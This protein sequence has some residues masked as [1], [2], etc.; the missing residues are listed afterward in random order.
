MQAVLHESFDDLNKI[1]FL[2]FISILEREYDVDL[3]DLKAKG[4][5]Y[6][7]DSRNKPASFNSAVFSQ[8]KK[9][10]SPL[11]LYVVLVILLFGAF[12][13]FELMPSMNDNNQIQKIDNSAIENAQKNIEPVVEKKFE[14][15][16]ESLLSAVNNNLQETNITSNIN[17]VVAKE[18]IQKQD[19]QERAKSL[20]VIPKAKVWM[21]YID[22]K[23]NQKY[24]KNLEKEMNLDVNKNWLLLFGHGNLSIEVDGK[25]EEFNSSQNI[26]FK[27]VD[28]KFS[29]IDLEEFKQLNKDKKW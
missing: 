11:F 19:I 9:K 18:E 26:R 28:G 23:T 2:G 12:L 24:E 21:G 1:H 6:F 13:Y 16:N 15:S 14:D 4:L 25:L 10:S 27:Y 17:S 7:N 20:R 22:I 3:A 8:G 5:A 29:Q